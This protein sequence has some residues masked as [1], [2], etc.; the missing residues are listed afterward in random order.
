LNEGDQR[1]GFFT[2]IG[3]Y[4]FAYGGWRAL[5]KSEIFWLS[6]MLAVVSMRIWKSANWWQIVIE[7]VPTLLGLSLAALTLFLGVGSEEFRT[8]LAGRESVGDVS[9]F[10]KTAAVFVHFLVIQATAL[11][12]AF[13]AS[14]IYAYPVLCGFEEANNFARPIFWALGYFFFIYA[15][16]T[17]LAAAFAVFEVVHWFDEFVTA[18][19]RGP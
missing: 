19:K 10:K 17:I 12:M 14:A 6:L 4:W 1:A 11:L 16:F 7:T 5:L 2:Q 15:L 13:L 8:W 3:D 9:P 18:K